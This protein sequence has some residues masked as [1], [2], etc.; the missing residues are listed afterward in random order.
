[1]EVN[2]FD[3]TNSYISHYTSGSWDASAL[4]SATTSGSMH[5]MTRSNITSLSPFTVAD[6]NSNLDLGIN[7]VVA[8]NQDIVLYPNPTSGILYF[9]TAA[10]PGSIYISDISGRV[11]RTYTLDAN[12]NHI[13]VSDLPAGLYNIYFYGDNISTG[14]KFVKE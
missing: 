3:R 6:N 4:A 2:G 1:M 9:N 10:K 12:R 14:K 13:S 8:N 7:P 11:L 5:S